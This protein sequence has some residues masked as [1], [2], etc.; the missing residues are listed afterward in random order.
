MRARAER[1]P[2]RFRGFLRKGKQGRASGLRRGLCE[3]FRWAPGGRGSV[4]P[5]P[6]PGMIRTEACS[7]GRSSRGEGWWAR[8]LAPFGGESGAGAAA[9]P[10]GP[11]IAKPEAELLPPASHQ[12]PLCPVLQGGAPETRVAV[13]VSGAAAGRT[14]L[15]TRSRWSVHLNE[16]RLPL[17]SPV[18][19][20]LTVL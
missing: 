3:S 1:A 12:A 16:G 7:L 19:L 14:P 9:G 11:R 4:S 2:Q 17:K 8:G 18:R 10:R 13:S 15:A 20:H 5:A 6:G